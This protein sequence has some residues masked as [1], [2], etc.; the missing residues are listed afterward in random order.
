MILSHSNTTL[1]RHHYLLG[2]YPAEKP[3]SVSFGQF[4]SSNETRKTRRQS[5]SRAVRRLLDHALQHYSASY[6]LSETVSIGQ[7]EKTSNGKP[8]LAG[9][10]SPTISL[11]HSANWV[12]CAISSAKNLGIDIETVK[13][14]DWQTICENFFHPEESIWILNSSEEEQ[15]I[16]GLICWCRKEALT[17]AL[18]IGMTVSPSEIAFSPD[19]ALISLPPSLGAIAGW[20][21]QTDTLQNQAVMATVWKN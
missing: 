7:I 2:E 21:S 14:R 4:E 6:S 13:Q 19:G 12:A 16:R 8:Y 1:N 9:L 3:V 20:A 17:K 5:Q 11:S 15:N 10:N 18:G